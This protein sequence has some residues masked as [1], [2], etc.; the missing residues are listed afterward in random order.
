MRIPL[1][2]FSANPAISLS[3]QPNESLSLRQK[4]SQIVTGSSRTVSTGSAPTSPAFHRKKAM[5]MLFADTTKDSDVEFGNDATILPNLAVHQTMS[6]S[7]T[8][9]DRREVDEEYDQ[10]DTGPKSLPF[11]K[12]STGG[13]FQRLVCFLCDQ[14][15][16][17]SET[18]FGVDNLWKL[19]ST[20]IGNIQFLNDFQI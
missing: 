18:K 3:P 10:C 13:Y 17:L 2:H 5:S 14:I 20:T 4:M 9:F 6:S 1:E 19:N 8:S 15:E 11:Q 12:H 7:L 16:T